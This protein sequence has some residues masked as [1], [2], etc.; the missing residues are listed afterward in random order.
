MSSLRDKSSAYFS[1]ECSKVLT[2]GYARREKEVEEWSGTA[3][4][5]SRESIPLEGC[6]GYPYIESRARIHTER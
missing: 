1:V 3:R 4:M 6:P 2:I 5:K